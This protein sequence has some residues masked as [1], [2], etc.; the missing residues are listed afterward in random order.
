[1]APLQAH[2][3]HTL[4]K[5]QLDDPTIGPALR[6]ME[7]KENLKPDAIAR[8]GPAVRRLVQLW[9][10]LFVENGI[11]KRQYESI[12]GHDSWTQFVVPLKLRDEI[13][14]ELHSGA[15]EG[16]LGEDKTVG[17]VRERFYWPGM[18]RDM[19]QWIRTCPECAT[20]KSPF[21]RN[22]APLKTVASGFPMQVVAV[23]ILGPLP[24]STAG[25]SYT[26]I[27]SDYFTKWLKAFAI[28][29][30]EAVTVAPKL[31]DQVLCRFS[32]PDQLHSD[33]G[34]QF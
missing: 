18:Q 26:L 12:R 14:K 5:A 30:L 9:D 23:D 20:R 28:P 32:P 7:A 19:I 4:R 13:L 22:R 31:V 11:L 34:K 24:E 16:H 27:V 33:Q 3:P 17:K 2:S 29:N 15:L 10:R 6:A 25:N 8:G 21:Q 1:M